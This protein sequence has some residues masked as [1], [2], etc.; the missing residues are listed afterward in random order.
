[1]KHKLTFVYGGA[2]S[3]INQGR[4]RAILDLAAPLSDLSRIGKMG[5]AYPLVLTG[6]EN[7]L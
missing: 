3:S 5:N 7:I 4:V 1:L 2:S 6:I